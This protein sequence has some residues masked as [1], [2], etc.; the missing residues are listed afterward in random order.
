MGHGVAGGT[1]A[2]ESG[3]LCFNLS[4]ATYLDTL[5][6]FLSRRFLIYRTSVTSGPRRTQGGP[7]CKALSPGPDIADAQ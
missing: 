2:S 3:S 4:S 1:Q 5:F 6:A 7:V